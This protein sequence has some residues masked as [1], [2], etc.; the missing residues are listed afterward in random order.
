M[1]VLSDYNTGGTSAVLP[2]QALSS[3]NPEI[4]PVTSFR[5]YYLLVTSLIEITTLW[6]T[7]S[8]NNEPSQL[9]V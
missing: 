5:L 6:T 7:R 3:L 8:K 1:I 9:N 4:I 2:L